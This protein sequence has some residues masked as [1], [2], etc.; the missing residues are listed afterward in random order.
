MSK[1]SQAVKI[2]RRA[3]HMAVNF[4]GGISYELNPL[5]NMKMVTA[6]SIFGEP[7]YP[8]QYNGMKT[9]KVMLEKKTYCI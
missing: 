6:S 1:L 2:E 3:N 4:M 8:D 7:Q 9:S 5:D